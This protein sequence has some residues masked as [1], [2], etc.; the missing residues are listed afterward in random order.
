MTDG[1]EVMFFDAFTLL[2]A[3]FGTCQLIVQ[4]PILSSASRLS[5]YQTVTLFFIISLSACVCD[6]FPVYKFEIN[7]KS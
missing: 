5:S 6:D 2:P 4:R 1:E 3:P 7:V